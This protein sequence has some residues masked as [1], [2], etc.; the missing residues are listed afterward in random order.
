M[1]EKKT[2][3][4][5]QQAKMGTPAAEKRGPVIPKGV[6]RILAY[7]IVCIAGSIGFARVETAINEERATREEFDKA[8]QREESEEQEELLA[9]CQL[10]NSFKRNSRNGDSRIV[11]AFK[12]AFLEGADTPEEEQNVIDR[13]EQARAYVL[14]GRGPEEEDR[15]CDKSGK[16]DDGDYIR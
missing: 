2:A 12:L 8:E 5:K 16:I 11:D 4:K 1:A 15:D 3:D 6:Q 10:N 9:A 13:A 7:L 14:E